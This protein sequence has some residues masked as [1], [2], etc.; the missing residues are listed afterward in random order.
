M[1]WMVFGQEGAPPGLSSF[2]PLIL[3]TFAIFYFIVIRP[4]Q[5][6]Q[7]DLR[8]AIDALKKGDR[9]L[10][11]GGIFGTIT[12]FK[13]NVLEVR[14]G[15]V[16]RRQEHQLANICLNRRFAPRRPSVREALDDLA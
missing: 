1:S 2:F 10:T 15:E 5:K 13:E 8:K 14:V 11:T 4:Q 16:Q 6:K 7:K 3:A 9:V 12:G